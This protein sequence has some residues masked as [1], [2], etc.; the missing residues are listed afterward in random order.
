MHVQVI[1]HT[2]FGLGLKEYIRANPAVASESP[3]TIIHSKISDFL[4]S[5]GELKDAEARDEFY[6]AV[7]GDSSSE[8]D[9]SDNDSEEVN[10]VLFYFFISFTRNI[11]T[12]AFWGSK[13]FPFPLSGKK[14]QIKKCFMG[15]SKPCNKADVR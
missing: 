13:W 6:D 5:N 3:T 2:W 15:H 8:D 7:S 1:Y 11:L 12:F 14:N 9:D 10:K 4:A